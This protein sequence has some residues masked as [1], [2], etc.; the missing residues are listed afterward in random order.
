MER[1]N[2]HVEDFLQSYLS[3]E[4]PPRFA[5]LISGQWG[6]GKT[7]LVKNLLEATKKPYLFCSLYGLTS[8]SQIEDIFFQQL[9]PLLSSKGAK[10]AGNL[11]RGALAATLRFDIMSSDAADASV[12]L[13]VPSNKILQE[14]SD[15][16]G[17]ILVFDD[18]ERC[19]M[20]VEQ[21]LGYINKFCEHDDFRVIII[22]NE[23]EILSSDE[24]KDKTP[25]YRRTKEKLI[26][27]TL[28]VSAEIGSAFDSFVGEVNH[29]DIKSLLHT[30][31]PRIVRCFAETGT[32]NLRTLSQVLW[33]FERLF[34]KLQS[35]SH[36]KVDGAIEF[37]LRYLVFTSEVRSGSLSKDDFADISIAKFGSTTGK[38]FSSGVQAFHKKYLSIDTDDLM[39]VSVTSF[40]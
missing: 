39:L 1:S 14:F 30:N 33:H 34:P 2:R 29:K 32:H 24:N 5:V 37:L 9:H 8:T 16:N 13:S 4:H 7:Y 23:D 40:L 36:F 11:L 6:S 10:L 18:L 3:Q 27:Q 12:A 17:R 21:A 20:P 38:T 19:A 28:S 26:G 25:T 22:G 35:T 15:Y 31:K